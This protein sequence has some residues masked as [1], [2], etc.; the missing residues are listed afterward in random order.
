M[1]IVFEMEDSKL[2]VII[3]GHAQMKF[4]VYFIIKHNDLKNIYR[5]NKIK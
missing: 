2:D 1:F 4:I 3:S 5:K